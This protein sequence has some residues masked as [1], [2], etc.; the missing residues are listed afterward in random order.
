[1]SLL[2]LLGEKV[3]DRPDEGSSRSTISQIRKKNEGLFMSVIN[4]SLRCLPDEMHP[5][6][7]E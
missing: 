3:A 6:I 4:P 1:M 7:S 2:P 5:L